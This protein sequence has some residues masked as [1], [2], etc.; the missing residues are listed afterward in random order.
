MHRHPS[1]L[2]RV[3]HALAAQ[4]LLEMLAFPDGAM[5]LIAPM[6]DHVHDH[7]NNVA[8]HLHAN[9][10]VVQGGKHAGQAILVVD[11]VEGAYCHQKMK[12]FVIVEVGSVAALDAA[13]RQCTKA[14][15]HL[16][17]RIADEFIVDSVEGA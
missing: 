14:R 3:Q 9:G 11:S 17:A 1:S 8:S 13:M 16:R 4:G 2:Y 10:L 15:E 7:Y 12:N 5:L 6:H